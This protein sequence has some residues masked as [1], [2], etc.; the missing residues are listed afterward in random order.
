MRDAV[1]IGAVVLVALLLRLLFLSAFAD[2]PFYSRHFS[3]SK[4]YVDLA[5]RMLAGESMT[6]AWFMSPLYP[7]MISLTMRVT[8]DYLFWV[9]FLQVLFGCGTVLLVW[10]IGISVF[11]RLTGIIA[12]VLTAVSAPLIFYDSLL[13]I[14][15]LLTFFVIAGLYFLLAAVRSGRAGDWLISGVFIG[16]AVVTRASVV[17]FVPVLLIA[18]MFRQRTGPG[19]F[20]GVAVWTAALFVLM[21]P[22]AIHNFSAEG[23]I[24]PVTSSFGFNLYAGNNDEAVGLYHMP[25]P[26]D[27]YTDPNGHDYV[28]GQS[29]RTMNSAEVSSW[30]RDRAVKW[31]V[32]N[33]G[34]FI[35]LLTKKLLLMLHP[36]DID[37]IGMSMA[38][39][40]DRYGAVPG[41]PLVLFPVV[42]VLAAAGF[43]ASWKKGNADWPLRLFFLTYLLITAVF[44]VSGRLRLPLLP[45]MHLYAGSAVAI[46]LEQLRKKSIDRR[47]I[48]LGAG[49]AVGAVILAIQPQVDQRFEQEYLKLG[50]IAFDGGSYSEAE[51]MFTRSI[52]ERPTMD[53]YVNAG[54]ANAAQ[55]KFAEASAAYRQAIAMD[56]TSALAWFNYGNMWMQRNDAPRAHACWVRAVKYNPKFAPAR[57]N[58]GLLFLQAGR[59]KEAEEQ[60]SVYLRLERDPAMRAQIQR[61]LDNVRRMVE[62]KE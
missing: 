3:D 29:G 9:R 26:V 19:H 8:D 37:Q 57:R 59:P 18:W 58:L 4:I 16:L 39:V 54:N 52:G 20:R 1:L 50:Q 55:G 62:G 21:L 2:T 61:D 46:V 11:D 31:V 24:Q 28:E 15:S 30:W 13:L 34:K 48:V 42:V 47:M 44:F 56:S 38:F 7:W 12:A 6:R 10:R 27:L 5:Q 40:T 22:T 32:E 36:G 49:A 53:G 23:V 41:M 17:V 45:L 14:D 51:E 60:L 33:P 25:D 43:A 35:A